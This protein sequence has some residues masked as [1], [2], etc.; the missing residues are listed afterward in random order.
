M[1]NETGVDTSNFAK[2]TDLANLKSG[3]DKLDIHNSNNIPNK[4]RNL[5]IQVYELDID[6]IVPVP[7]GLSKLSDVVKNFVF[8]KMYV[9]LRSKILKTQYVTL[10]T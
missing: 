3:V 7:V 8:K 2:K 9:M 1:E 6:K 5:K 10:L 4:L